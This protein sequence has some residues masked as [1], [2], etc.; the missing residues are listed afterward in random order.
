[1]FRK[2]SYYVETIEMDARIGLMADEFLPGRADAT[3]P[4]RIW[5]HR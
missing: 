2:S 3:G 5:L 4:P 1:M